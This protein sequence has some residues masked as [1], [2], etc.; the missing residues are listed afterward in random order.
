MASFDERN[1]AEY[2]PGFVATL[3]GATPQ[4]ST[5]IDMQGW[6]AL[7]YVV[8]TGTVTDAGTATG[9]TFEVQHSDDTVGANFTAVPDSGLIG[10]ETDLTIDQDTQDDV[11]IGSIGYRGEKRYVRIV[12]TGTSGTDATVCVSATK[13]HGAVMVE[14][15]IQAPIA[16]T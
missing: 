14:A 4:N 8:A 9:I 7:T 6:E 12:A 11:V 1:N 16:A 3:S 5:I 10:L 2:A 15:T 13:R